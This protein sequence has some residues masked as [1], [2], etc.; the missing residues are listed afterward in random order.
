V[1]PPF[2]QLKY[3]MFFMLIASDSLNHPHIDGE[4]TNV[5]ICKPSIVFRISPSIDDILNI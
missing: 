2:T 5:L 1:L 4:Q 3:I